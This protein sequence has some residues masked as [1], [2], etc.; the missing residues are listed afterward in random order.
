VIEPQ[1]KVSFLHRYFNP[2]RLYVDEFPKNDEKFML[3]DLT[4]FNSTDSHTKIDHI[5]GSNCLSFCNPFGT[6]WLYVKTPPSLALAGSRIQLTVE[7][8]V[9][10]EADIWIEYDS[11]DA[12]VDVVKHMP[13]AFKRTETI[14]IYQ[15][16]EWF[17]VTFVINDPRFEGRVNGAD[18]R[19]VVTTQ[20][21]ESAQI[22]HIKVDSDILEN[23][24]ENL[25]HHLFGKSLK[26]T[27]IE[28][29]TSDSPLVSIIMPVFNKAIFT[30]QCVQYM[31]LHKSN[32][33]F[34]LIIIDN[35]SDAHESNMLDL[36]TGAK[37][38]RLGYNSGF[39][40]ANNH[41]VS[42][43]RGDLLLFLN[44]DTIPREK[45]LDKLV[46]SYQTNHEVRIV[47]SKLIYP[48]SDQVQHAG[49]YFNSDCIPYHRYEFVDEQE[50]SVNLERT[51][52]AVTGAS[53]LTD[54]YL[55]R[56]L[57][58]FDEEY[59]NGYEDIDYCLKVRQAGFKVLYCPTSTL[60]HYNSLTEGRYDHE[61]SN[62]DKFLA[63]WR[64]YISE[65]I[66]P[67][68]DNNHPIT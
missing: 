1:G 56:E 17:E 2:L 33:A 51:V 12:S 16:G 7:L 59:L 42:M 38:V 49:L 66:L 23:S 36:V 60:Y 48:E 8:F 24:K 6:A 40:I 18:F 9:E 41:G 27:P 55:Y 20:P 15:V 32:I 63:R 13:G 30:L 53:M 43:A 34:E 4:T 67:T 19:V 14:K 25:N 50:E 26:N 10:F 47:G 61:D 22:R 39:S 54:G 52:P 64:D 31:Q 37:I 28:V 46:E 57:G 35:G 62:R 44:N 3:G 58:G 5:S 21:G 65:S 11:L 68:T 29:K 45:W